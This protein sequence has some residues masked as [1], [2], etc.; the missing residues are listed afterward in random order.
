M[1]KPSLVTPYEPL[2][3]EPIAGLSKHDSPY[4]SLHSHNNLSLS[5]QLIKP[6][7]CFWFR[8]FL[9]VGCPRSS[10]THSMITQSITGP[11][12]HDY[13]CLSPHSHYNLLFYRFSFQLAKP[14]QYFWVRQFLYVGCPRLSCTCPMITQSS[15]GLCKHD[16][17]YLSL[18]SHMDPSFYRFSL[19]L[20]K[21]LW[22][23]CSNNFYM[24]DV[25]DHPVPTLL[26]SSQQPVPSRHDCP[27]PMSVPSQ[28]P[29]P[30]VI[31]VQCIAGQTPM[32]L[33]GQTVLYVGC[34]RSS[35]ICPIFTQSIADPFRHNISFLLSHNHHNLSSID[36]VHS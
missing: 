12:R 3:H 28:L 13:P 4:L 5:L 15:A 17:P 2:V 16:S 21:P 25:P 11:S 36:S 7:Q 19:Q 14:I 26:S 35:C 23:F 27:V 24:W 32:V 10:R 30:I 8:W 18:H 33:L 9:H 29:Q 20:I 31:Q 22:Y 1:F 6:L 34:P